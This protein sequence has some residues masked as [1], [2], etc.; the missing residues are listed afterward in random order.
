MVILTQKNNWKSIMQ[1][2]KNNILWKQIIEK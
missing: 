1:Q 2:E